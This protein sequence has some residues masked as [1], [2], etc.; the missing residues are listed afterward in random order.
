MLSNLLIASLVG[1]NHYCNFE[2]SITLIN[3]GA[4]LQ[5]SFT[6]FLTSPVYFEFPFSKRFSFGERYVL[7]WFGTVIRGNGKTMTRQGCAHRGLCLADGVLVVGYCQSFQ[8]VV[9]K[10]VC[11]Q[12]NMFYEVVEGDILMTTV[13]TDTLGLTIS[14]EVATE[15]VRIGHGSILADGS[16][17]YSKAFKTY[18]KAK[19]IID[20]VTSYHCDDLNFDDWGSVTVKDHCPSDLSSLLNEVCLSDWTSWRSPTIKQMSEA[21]FMISFGKDFEPSLLDTSRSSFSLKSSKFK[22]RECRK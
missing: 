21:S 3:D 12:E 11:H 9:I 17:E 22:D 8:L 2:S 6:R 19:R 1:A 10:E 13:K 4:L 5:T 14:T 18:L 20:L 7:H 15:P 16:F